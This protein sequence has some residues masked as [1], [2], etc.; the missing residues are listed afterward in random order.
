MPVQ[1][2][3]TAKLRISLQAWVHLVTE[4]KF[5]IIEASTQKPILSEATQIA[6]KVRND[7]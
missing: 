1:L 4:G 6:Y 7:G 2:V 5:L 3:T